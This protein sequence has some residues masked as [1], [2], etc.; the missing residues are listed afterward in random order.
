MIRWPWKRK[1]AKPETGWL[2][3]VTFYT[4][5]PKQPLRVFVSHRWGSDDILRKLIAGY[6]E[7]NGV[8]IVT[9]MSLT[10][11]ERVEGPRGG[12]VDELKIKAEI[13]NRIAA[14]DLVIVPA[15]IAASLSRW[16]NWET[17]TAHTLRKP[18]LFVSDRPDRVRFNAYLRRLKAQ[19]YPVRLAQA[20][21]A[22]ILESVRQMT[23]R[24]H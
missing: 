5:E 10:P 17:E 21:R 2:K 13:R 3:D 24:L 19:N 1:P 12:K 14:S 18:I 8:D 20:D 15:H 23:G 9:D 4:D 7:S 22:D 6:L 16:I 11:D